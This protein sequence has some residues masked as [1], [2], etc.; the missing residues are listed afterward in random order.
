MLGGSQLSELQH[1]LVLNS[2]FQ[3]A[4][5]AGALEA[6]RERLE[7]SSFRFIDVQNTELSNTTR[8]VALLDPENV[9]KRGY[10]LTLLNG[11]TVS[12]AQD[13]QPGDQLLTHTSEGSILSEVQSINPEDHV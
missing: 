11:K 6:E 10:S 9:L 3:M 2:G 5:H 4:H 1:A 13:A 8:N 12:R 7:D